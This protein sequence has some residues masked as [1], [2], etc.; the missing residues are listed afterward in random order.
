M[1]LTARGLNFVTTFFLVSM[2][3]CSA[4]LFGWEIPPTRIEHSIDE[5]ET[6]GTYSITVYLPKYC[7]M[8]DYSDYI[9]H[10]CYL[11]IVDPLER[12]IIGMRYWMSGTPQAFFQQHPDASIEYPALSPEKIFLT[13]LSA[14]T[15]EENNWYKVIFNFTLKST[16]GSPYADSQGNWKAANEKICFSL[17]SDYKKSTSYT[18]PN[19][20]EDESCV[21]YLNGL[22]LETN[23]GRSIYVW[24]Q[25]I[26]IVNPLSNP[27]YVGQREKFFSFLSAPHGEMDN[28]IDTVFMSCETSGIDLFNYYTELRSFIAD[29]HSRGLKIHYLAGDPSWSLTS[30][31]SIAKSYID[32]V[33]L[34]NKSV[35]LNEQFDAIQ[36]DIEPYVSFGWENRWGQFIA[37][38]DELAQYINQKNDELEKKLEFGVVI[39]RWYDIDYDPEDTYTGS[40]YEQIINLADYIVIMNYTVHRAV[41]FQDAFDEIVYANSLNPVKK[42][43]LALETFNLGADDVHTSFWRQ[44]NKKLNIAVNAMERYFGNQL[45]DINYQSFAGVTVHFYESDTQHS[46]RNL[47]QSFFYPNS[48]AFHAP[49]CTV[50]SPE[51]NETLSGTEARIEFEIY[52]NDSTN[53]NVKIYLYREEFS[54]DIQPAWEGNV[55]INPATNIYSGFALIDTTSYTQSS[56]YKVRIEVLENDSAQVSNLRSYDESN[57]F[58]SIEND[59]QNISSAIRTVVH[60]NNPMPYITIN[61]NPSDLITSYTVIENIPEGSAPEDVEPLAQWDE[62]NSTLTWGPFI[63]NEPRQLR[64]ALRCE[65]GT[66]SVTGRCIFNDNEQPVSGNQSVTAVTN[67][68]NIS[69]V[70]NNSAYLTVTIQPDFVGPVQSFSITALLSGVSFENIYPSGYIG[71]DY[72]LWN[73]SDLSETL[74][75]DITGN[76]GTY[77]LQISGTISYSSSENF[78]PLEDELNYI[79]Y[80]TLHEETAERTITNNNTENPEILLNIVPCAN[81]V[82]Y[83]VE[84]ILPEGT[85]PI[86]IAQGGVWDQSNWKIIWGPFNDSSGRQLSYTLAGFN[87]DFIINGVVICDGS[88]LSINGDNE[89]FISGSDMP[90]VSRS[91]MESNSSN[92]EIL[93]TFYSVSWITEY[94]VIETIPDSIEPVHIN[95]EGVW[96]PQ[97]RTIT[98]GPFNDSSGRQFSYKIAGNSGEYLLSGTA[99]INRKDI[100]VSGQDTVTVTPAENIYYVNPN[101]DDA[102]DGS[103]SAPWKTIQY[104]VNN[105]DSGSTLI[106]QSGLYNESNGLVISNATNPNISGT[107]E[108][109]TRI[110][111]QESVEINVPDQ[112]GNIITITGSANIKIKYLNAEGLNLKGTKTQIGIYAQYLENCEIKNN[113]LVGFNVGIKLANCTNSVFDGNKCSHFFIAGIELISSTDNNFI[114][115]V[116]SKG[117]GF[118]VATLQPEFNP[119]CGIKL[120]N[121]SNYNVIDNN[122]CSDNVQRGDFGSSDTYNICYSAGVYINNSS[123]NTIKN[124]IFA[125]NKGGRNHANGHHWYTY[126]TA[127]IFTTENISVLSLYG[128]ILIN[129]CLYLESAD[130]NMVA[131][132]CNNVFDGSAL[133]F[134]LAPK[135][136]NWPQHNLYQPVIPSDSENIVLENN[137]FIND[138]SSYYHYWT[139]YIRTDIDYFH[140]YWQAIRVYPYGVIG[141][142]SCIMSLPVIDVSGLFS[143][144]FT[145]E[146]IKFSNNIVYSTLNRTTPSIEFDNDSYDGLNIDYNFI[147]SNL[148]M[149]TN[150][151]QEGENNIV[152]ESPLFK[153]FQTRNFQLLADSVC[154]NSGADGVTMGLYDGDYQWIDSDNDGMPDWWEIENGLNLLLDDSD[155]DPDNDGLTNYQEFYCRTDPMQADTDGD[156]LSDGEELSVYFTDPLLVDTDGDGMPDGW[157]IEY[158][159]NQL[160]DDADNDRDNDTLTNYQE[161]YYK[162]HPN[163]PDTDGDGLTDGN[164]ILVYGTNPLNADTDNDGLSDHDEIFIYFTNPLNPDTDGDGLTDGEEVLVYASNPL[165]IDTDNDGLDDY[166]EIY[167]YYTSPLNS[168]T[169]NDGLT[170]LAEKLLINNETQINSYTD[171]NQNNSSLAS[172]GT[173]YFVVWSSYMQDGK[174][175]EISGQL[176]DKYGSKI[177]SEIQINTNAN[178]NQSG[179]KIASNSITYFAVWTSRFQDGDFNGIFGQLFDKNGSKVGLEI[180]VNSYT[181]GQQ[182]HPSIASD[183]KNY[184]VVWH[185]IGQDGSETGVYGQLFDNDGVKIGDEIQ[186]NS[187]TE[188]DQ[189]YPVVSSNGKNYLVVWASSGQDGS[190]DGI[191]AQLIDNDGNIFGTEFQLNTTT[192]YH[193]NNPNVSSDGDRYLVVWDSEDQDDNEDIFGQFIDGIGN[194]VGDEFKINTYDNNDQIIPRLSSNGINYLVVWHGQGIYGGDSYNVYAQILDKNGV[195]IGSEL[196]INQYY[197]GFQGY[198]SIASNGNTFFV[199]WE[200]QYQDGSGFGIYGSLIK[201]GYGTDPLNPD[202][203]ND[204]LSDSAEINVYLTNPLNPDTDGDGM[205]DGWEIEHGLD[206]LVNDA[207][208][209]PDNDDLANLQE[210]IACTDPHNPDTDG[211]GLTDGE[212]VL[213]H[214]T[215]PLIT[216]TDGDVLT[217]YEEVFVYF[218]DPLNP[219]TDNDGLS[220]GDEINVYL[221]NPLNLDTDGDGMQDGWEIEHGLDPL[222]NDAQ[223]DPDNDGLS[224]LQEFSAGIDPNNPDTDEDGLTDGE[225]VLIYGTNPLNSDTDGDGIPDGIETQYEL[226]P[227]SKYLTV[228]NMDFYKYGFINYIDIASNGNTYLLVSGYY[229]DWDIDSYGF[230]SFKNYNSS[231]KLLTPSGAL[232]GEGENIKISET[233]HSQSIYSNGDNYLWTWIESSDDLYYLKAMLIAGMENTISPEFCIKEWDNVSELSAYQV[234]H[235]GSNY[236]VVFEGKDQFDN[237]G[238]YIILL[239]GN[240]NK[241][242]DEIKIDTQTSDTKNNISIVGNGTSCLVTW[243]NN[244]SDQRRINAKLVGVDNDG[245]YTIKEEFTVA[246]FQTSNQIYPRVES[247]EDQNYIVIWTDQE[248]QFIYGINI[249]PN[250]NIIGNEFSIECI[251]RTY[252][253]YSRSELIYS[254]VNI[255]HG[256]PNYFITWIE[257]LIGFG[258]SIIYA[259]CVSPDGQ[260]IGAKKEIRSI[261]SYSSFSTEQVSNSYNHNFLACIAGLHSFLNIAIID[262][263]QNNLRL[264]VPLSGD[265]N[266]GGFSVASNGS[267]FGLICRMIGSKG[268]SPIMFRLLAYQSPDDY[269]GDGISNDQEVLYGTDS[270]KFDT[271]NDGLSDHDEIYFFFTNPLNPD[272]DNDGLNDYEECVIYKTDPNSADTDGDGLTDYDELLVYKTDPCNPDTDGDRLTDYDEIN[273]YG[274]NPLH[275]YI[276]PAPIVLDAPGENHIDPIYRAISNGNRALIARRVN[277]TEISGY[278]IDN[279]GNFVTD[280]LML[281]N[282][283]INT[284]F[285]YS[286][287]LTCLNDIYLCAWVETSEDLHYSELYVRTIDVNGNTGESYLLTSSYSGFRG[288][289]ASS[290]GEDFMISWD[291]DAGMSYGIKLN[292]DSFEKTIF[293][294]ADNEGIAGTNILPGYSMFLREYYTDFRLSSNG[295]GYIYTTEKSSFNVMYT[296]TLGQFLSEEGLPCSDEFYMFQYSVLDSL[297]IGSNDDYYFLIR[298]S[299]YNGLYEGMFISPDGPHPDIAFE[300]HGDNHGDNQF[301]PQFIVSFGNDFLYAYKENSYDEGHYLFETILKGQWFLHPDSDTDNDGLKNLEETILGADPLNSDTDGDGLSDGDEVLIYATDPL[302]PDTDNDGMPDAYELRYTL[303]PLVDDAHEDVDNDGLINSDEF[304]YRTNPLNSDTDGDGL[305][306][307]EELIVFFTDPIN[308][309]TD[310]DGMPDGMELYAG[311]DPC[312]S[313]CMFKVQSMQENVLSDGIR[314][315]WTVTEQEGRHYYIYVK[316]D[317]A[318]ELVDYEGWQEDIIDNGDGTNSWTDP[319]AKLHSSRLYKVIVV[320]E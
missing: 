46:Y 306:D 177:G 88:A 315:T 27:A 84:E 100:P 110:I 78:Y 223:E 239:D 213:V 257:K 53:I 102:N 70:N 146:N 51:N 40:G 35:N 60:N 237:D 236:V 56:D 10:S 94:I 145:A 28:A 250:G 181:K 165:I 234:S 195:K 197:L 4:A 267:T 138:R 208:E 320:R 87:G 154:I 14:V 201:A 116:C 318:W 79:T 156:G 45:S 83:S 126:S 266:Y 31:L 80:I 133:T 182:V 246:T 262:E 269:D 37:N 113:T 232:I 23:S 297:R 281:I 29:A 260:L 309:D 228:K 263:N 161:F 131:G 209:D 295:N 39:P 98:W 203:D 242:G 200:T 254:S 76:Q 22:P 115:N 274:T 299:G 319:F 231:Y 21:S 25:A 58:V 204:G 282:E 279:Q 106:I 191:Y 216:D 207:Q 194:K 255:T 111:A 63:D 168:D 166:E 141:G 30:N 188:S 300:L 132:I 118:R 148:S 105:I 52:D 289:I 93:I 193:Q 150:L 258:T 296:K 304:S 212:E 303:D 317:T 147:S 206:P 112:V 169:D 314:I 13:N 96:N 153:S 144:Y 54:P 270:F 264:N 240:G 136:G 72:I 99:T 312:D 81:T 62:I 173:N 32:K 97:T 38:I 256:Y 164:E 160:S 171:S 311:A 9:I 47:K 233:A 5:I 225:E 301:W 229:V 174:D 292:P 227:L 152:S 192:Q 215:N 107:A 277:E 283:F 41:A 316:T 159:L 187:Y 42:V 202:T 92:P 86:A 59:P 259:Q 50:L 6:G 284:S 158:G 89:V 210:F 219:D 218:T 69:I 180:Q 184:F 85:A 221:T 55:T 143:S 278:I 122:V 120:T 17:A 114:R 175:W 183:G 163:N 1:K 26:E 135:K 48:T 198:A 170:D 77:G 19:F 16:P 67:K 119:T 265:Y 307:Y 134:K 217:D 247:N 12:N 108:K 155:D 253:P 140:G 286:F 90:Q 186:I 245:L 241:I 288:M 124:N 248:S 109:M 75:F 36:L 68:L 244:D 294:I 3:I 196:Q 11:K 20:V 176:Y 302:N 149:L 123:H 61:V 276:T 74:S 130:R 8:S 18:D 199:T 214:G 291:D 15:A 189:A 34:Y 238:I 261:S 121:Q 103:A 125:N 285:Y 64:Y 249:D 127:G 273:I 280:Q 24:G 179:A 167:I 310:G 91:V 33:V 128:N 142:E 137:V 44:G 7:E 49:V 211:D 101:G 73:L 65:D 272:I 251:T 139:W 271:D 2:F 287:S 226:D 308:P 71:G 82:Y 43:Y 275:K 224:N 157:E 178:D 313:D 243:V 57:G 268:Y 220:D 104:A 290:N 172:D 252:Y 298:C 129:N 185:S 151:S 235:I 190:G 230:T 293:S 117:S 305:T 162:T 205:Q 66:Y 222:V 95:F